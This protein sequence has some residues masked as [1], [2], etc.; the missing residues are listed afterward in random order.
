MP[1]WKDQ[2]QDEIVVAILCHGK[3]EDAHHNVY[4]L[5]AV[6]FVNVIATIL[7]LGEHSPI[8][9]VLL[10]AS[11]AADLQLIAGILVWAVAVYATD[12]GLSAAVMATVVSLGAGAM[13][14]NAVS[15]VLLVVETVMQP[16]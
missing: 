3:K 9:A 8:G 11:I 1:T 13:V 10:A 7:K 4:V 2:N 12:I 15:V 16:R 5:Y 14:A 6:F